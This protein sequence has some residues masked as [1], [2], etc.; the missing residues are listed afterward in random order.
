MHIIDL[1]SY[2]SERTSFFFLNWEI[3]YNLHCVWVHYTVKAGMFCMYLKSFEQICHWASFM[4]L[5]V[6]KTILK[7]I[8]TICR[9]MDVE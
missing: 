1:S 8:T 2:F 4:K 9:Q 6:R 5:E 7:I 3:G